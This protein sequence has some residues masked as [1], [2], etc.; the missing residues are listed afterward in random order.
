MINNKKGL[1]WCLC[2]LCCETHLVSCVSLILSRGT[3]RRRRS[4]S[5]SRRWSCRLSRSGGIGS[6]CRSFPHRNRI[7]S[8]LRT[9]PASG[10]TLSW[11]LCTTSSAF[12][13]SA[14]ISKHCC[15]PATHALTVTSIYYGMGGIMIILQLFK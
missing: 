2:S 4:F 8:S 13:S 14:C 11:C 3:Q 7:P 6:L 15:C 12:S 10:P 1:V 9:S 5:R